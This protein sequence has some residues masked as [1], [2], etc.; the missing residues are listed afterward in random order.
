[1]ISV[2]RGIHRL[3][4]NHRNGPMSSLKFSLYSFIFNGSF[5]IIASSVRFVLHFTLL[6]CSVLVF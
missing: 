4:N 1:M 2:F 5:T 6:L 3:T